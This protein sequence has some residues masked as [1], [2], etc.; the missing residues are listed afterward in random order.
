MP[1]LFNFRQQDLNNV[2]VLVNVQDSHVFVLRDELREQP[3]A[4]FECGLDVER[5]PLQFLIFD[6]WAIASNFFWDCD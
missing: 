3:D 2:V 4:I 5:D 1:T 6:R